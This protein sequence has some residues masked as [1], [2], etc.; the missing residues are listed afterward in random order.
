ME[1]LDVAVRGAHRALWAEADALWNRAETAQ[2]AADKSPLPLTALAMVRDLKERAVHLQEVANE[3]I[4]SWDDYLAPPSKEP[5]EAL[6]E[7]NQ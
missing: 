4:F 1:R 7:D 2:E 3:L 6:K 5:A